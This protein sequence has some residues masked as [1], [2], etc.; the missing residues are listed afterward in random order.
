MLRPSLHSWE[1]GSR[2]GLATI[3][4][5]LFAGALKMPA[6]EGD[7]PCLRG[8]GKHAPDVREATASPVNVAQKDHAEPSSTDAEASGLVPSLRALFRRLLAPPP[9]GN[10]KAAKLIGYQIRLDLYY[11]ADDFFG[12]SR[13]IEYAEAVC[14]LTG[15]GDAAPPDPDTDSPEG[16]PTVDEIDCPT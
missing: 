4:V 11:G 16:P 6:M 8:D 15:G 7:K 3:C 12:Q 1:S 2:L 5:V 14:S 9:V 13:D 10:S